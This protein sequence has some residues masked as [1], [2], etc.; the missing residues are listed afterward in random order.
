[1]VLIFVV[2]VNGIDSIAT[3]HWTIEL[4]LVL[5]VLCERN[6]EN[7]DVARVEN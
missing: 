3:R 2:C 1:M 5:L 4:R 7:D 6:S